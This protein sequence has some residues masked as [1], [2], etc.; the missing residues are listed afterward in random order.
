[1]LFNNSKRYY[2]IYYSL[3]IVVAAVFLLD[4]FLTWIVIKNKISINNYY[5]IIQKENNIN[6][7]Q[8]IKFGIIYL[9]VHALIDG[10]M[11]QNKA[12]FFAC[13]YIGVVVLFFVD[14]LYNRKRKDQ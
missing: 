1:L 10:N 3:G 14:F 12:T 7:S 6:L 13:L 9:N 2:D 8:I 5:L 4:L 11:L